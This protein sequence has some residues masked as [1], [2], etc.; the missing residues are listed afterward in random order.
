MRVAIFS[1]VHGNLPALAA[2]MSHIKQQA[3]DMILFAGDLCL[4]GTRPSECL[5]LVQQADISCVYGN[6]DQEVAGMP[7]LHDIKSDEWVADSEAD[8]R[9][10]IAP[11][12]LPSVS[13]G[14][15]A[16]IIAWT[17]AQLTEQGR[18]WLR[19]LPFYR[20]VSP[21]LSPRD[22]L[23]VVHANPHDVHQHIY[24]D[25]KMQKS[26]YDEVRQ[27]DADLAHLLSDLDAGIL[28]F[29]HLHVHNIRHWDQLIL[30]NISSV[31]LPKDRDI[32]AKYG[33]FTWEDGAWNIEHQFVTYDVKAE[34]DELARLKLPGW[35]E[36][37]DRLQNAHP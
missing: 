31:S 17:Q 24:P 5:E 11:P 14:E 33:L 22:D 8:E 2:V 3:P 9:A 23:L 35:Q 30:A 37:A 1:D 20:R 28:A 7:I 29:G 32:R 36:K 4:F 10:D 27:T 34:I 6:T 15:E 21:S 12:E 25:E 18:A 26:L 19:E 13:P 16:E